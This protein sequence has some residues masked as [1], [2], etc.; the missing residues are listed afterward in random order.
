MSEQQIAIYQNSSGDLQVKVQLH[1]KNLWL[2]QKQIGEL[3]GK[4][5]NTVS[6]HIKKIYT[7]KELKE[8][9]TSTDSR[10]FGNPENT[11]KT[12]VKPTKYYNL[13]VILA[14]WY[15]VNSERAVVFRKRATKTLKE[16]IQRG[17]IM[18]D[19]R[20]KEGNTIEGKKDFE[21]M[22][23]RVREIRF[24]EMNLYDKIKALLSTASNYN[25]S[26]EETKLF[27]KTLQNKFHYAITGMTAT[28]LAYNRSDPNKPA[29]GMQSIKGNIT[30]TKATTGKNYLVEKE[31]KQM[32]LL[33]EQ[34]FAFAELQY[35]LER[36]LTMEQWMEK[37]HEVLKMSNL[38]ILENAWSIRRDDM[39][40]YIEKQIE[41]YQ[42]KRWSLEAY[43]EGANYLLDKSSS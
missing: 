17:F 2:S 35:S 12:F 10:N 37:L 33:C 13:D 42:E 29:L 4:A 25:E 3:Y 15:K 39:K 31:L 26:K 22:M 5:W 8:Q 16:Y 11:T 9:G 20:L 14:V 28:E 43:I 38:E 41:E 27:Y 21:G 7:D 34:F 1:E 36:E 24:S 18:D 23:D 40:K 30:K 32:F 19:E 6:E